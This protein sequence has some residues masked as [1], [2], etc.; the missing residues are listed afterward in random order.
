MLLIFGSLGTSTNSAIVKYMN[1]KK[2]PQLFV[3]SGGAVER[4]EEL[5][6]DDGRRPSYFREGRIYAKFLL[7]EKPDGKLAV[8]YQNDDYGKDD[9]R[10]LRT[11]SATRPR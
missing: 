11:R 4:S 1:V 10:G 7:K 3:P 5:P 8:V 6:V 2:V 9:L